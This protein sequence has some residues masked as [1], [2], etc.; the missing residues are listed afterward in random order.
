MPAKKKPKDNGEHYRFEYD[1]VKLDP[2]RIALV[3]GITHPIQIGMLKKVLRAGTAHK[4]LRE[5]LEDIKQAVDRY[6]E[7]L[8]EDGVK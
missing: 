8:D 3:Y 4:S 7:M 2:A 1:G 5:D 6:V